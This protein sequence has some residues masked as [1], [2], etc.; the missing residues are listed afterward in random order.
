MSRRLWELAAVLFAATILYGMMRSTPLYSEMTSP[1]PVYGEQGKRIDTRAFAFAIVNVHL[2]R[3]VRTESFGRTQDYT[4][5]G[6]WLVIEAA[7]EA[8]QESSSLTMANWLGPSGI[9]YALSQRFSTVPGFMTTEGLQPGLPRPILLA[10]EV[11]ESEVPGATL[12]V[13]RSYM[14]PLDEEIRVPMTGL[15]ATDIR[16]VLTLKRSSGGV[17]WILEAE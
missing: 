4:T 13:A 8:K 3:M 2:A 5:S 6:V 15:S 1:V 10:F 9:S 17:P 14:T 11:P 16:D 7:A 12:V